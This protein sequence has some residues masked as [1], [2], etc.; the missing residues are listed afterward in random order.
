MKKMSWYRRCRY[1]VECG[2]LSA[3]AWSIP[4]MP[5][6][7]VLAT[8]RLV[9]G[10]A[11][12]FDRRGRELGLKNL[13]LAVQHGDLDLGG[14]DYREVLRACYNNFAQCFLDL[15]W[16]A[17]A[18]QESVDPWIEIENE[19]A[20]GRL[21]KADRGAIFLTPH[22]GMFECASLIL[23][24]HGTKLNIIAQHLKNTSL[25]EIFQRARESNGHQVLSRDGAALKLFKVVKQGGNIALLP[26]LNVPPQKLAVPVRVF[27]IPTSLTSIHVEISR[28]CEVPMFVVVCEPRPD[29]RIVLRVLDQITA[30]SLGEKTSI[31]ATTQRVW[32]QLEQTIR[33]CPERWLWMYN[34][35]RY[36]AAE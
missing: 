32:D 8:A 13:R 10:L 12:K 29:G 3:V 28:R 23:G 36:R 15:F 22:F 35:W 4:R 11:M 30:T 26:D 25:I 17:G 7:A 21:L 5:R 19:K 2:A 1:A 16:F 33:K 27:G 20:L 14:R 18:T 9:G 34:H 31:Q 24:F 6:R